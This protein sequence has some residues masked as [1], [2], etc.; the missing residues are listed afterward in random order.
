ME[1]PD[2]GFIFPPHNISILCAERGAAWR[3]LVISVERTGLNSPEEMAFILLMARLN[4][5]A[6]CDADSFRSLHGCVLCSK[7]SLKRFRGTDDELTHLF[8][9]ARIEVIAFLKK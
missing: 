4:N 7:Q 1:N 3:N 8:E 2:T 5:C 6:T 9:K